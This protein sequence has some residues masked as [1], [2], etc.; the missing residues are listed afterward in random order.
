[1]LFNL[2][3]KRPEQRLGENCEKNAAGRKEKIP[4]LEFYQSCKGKLVPV[5]LP[6]TLIVNESSL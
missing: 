1:M 4:G 6:I 5:S 2:V 3:S